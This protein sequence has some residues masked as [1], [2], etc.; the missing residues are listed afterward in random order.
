MIIIVR[1]YI[2]VYDDK[3]MDFGDMI[4]IYYHFLSLDVTTNGS[5]A[6]HY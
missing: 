6:V 4:M 3:K 2:V 5:F 1:T